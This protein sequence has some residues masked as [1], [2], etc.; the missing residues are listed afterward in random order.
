M[1]SCSER[2]RPVPDLG[3][4]ALPTRGGL[5]GLLL[6]GALLVPASPVEAKVFLTVEEALDL[7]FEGCRVKR[8]TVYLTDGE[9]ARAEE[10]AGSDIESAIVY[11]YVADCGGKP[12]GTAY[13]DAH[14]VRTLPETL[15]VVV[16]PKGEVARVEILAFNEP[17]DYIPRDIWYEQFLDEEL[18]RDLALGRSIRAVTGATLT[19][20]AG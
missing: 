14:R 12:G 20:R 4:R 9:K 13:F 17:E 19:A 7:A 15:M 10:L 8:T 6:L 3:F 5:V 1:S 11:P 16:T 2:R 18:D